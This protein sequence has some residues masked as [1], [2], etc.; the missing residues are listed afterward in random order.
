[1]NSS[2][3]LS[4][5][6]VAVVIAS[7]ALFTTGAIAVI[8]WMLRV[9]MKME[10]LSIDPEV[11]QLW[12]IDGEPIVVRKVAPAGL[13]WREVQWT[14]GEGTG[15]LKTH[16]DTRQDWELRIKKRAVMYTGKKI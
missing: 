4:G 15:N 1:M 16:V 10:A 11:G 6:L 9:R 2:V 13:T 7:A 12:T 3:H 5:D 8:V 14:T